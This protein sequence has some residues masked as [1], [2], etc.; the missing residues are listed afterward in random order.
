MDH[1]L[2]LLIFSSIL[3]SIFSLSFFL[4]PKLFPNVSH[5]TTRPL[6]FPSFFEICFLCVFDY[7][8]TYTCSLTLPFFIFC[9]PA[10]FYILSCNRVSL[11]IS[12]FPPMSYSY[13][14]RHSRHPQSISSSCISSIPPC[15]SLFFSLPLSHLQS[16]PFLYFFIL[17]GVPDPIH[18]SL[19]KTVDPLSAITLHAPLSQPV[20]V[21]SNH[22]S[23][24]H[25]HTIPIPFLSTFSFVS[26]QPIARGE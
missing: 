21:F 18:S 20:A 7:P 6:F 25:T 14:I 23:H 1:G 5:H 15:L 3:P 9:F 12:M 19:F 10:S 8:P 24:T 11:L 2:P 26:L 17:R 13:L 16:F 22:F 4:L